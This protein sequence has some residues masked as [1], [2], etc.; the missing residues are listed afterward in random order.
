MGK[1]KNSFIDQ[2]GNISRIISAIVK[3]MSIK[4]FIVN[5]RAKGIGYHLPEP[6]KDPRI[7]FVEEELRKRNSRCGCKGNS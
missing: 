7:A 1:N 2:I 6:I 5:T 4:G 3:P